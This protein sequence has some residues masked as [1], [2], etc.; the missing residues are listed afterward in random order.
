MHERLTLSG[1]PDQDTPDEDLFLFVDEASRLQD[2]FLP[3]DATYWQVF[4]GKLTEKQLRLVANYVAVWIRNTSDIHVG[5]VAATEDLIHQGS[6]QSTRPPQPIGEQKAALDLIAL[7]NVLAACLSLLRCP[8]F[9]TDFPD[10]TD[11]KVLKAA[12]SRE[13][14]ER[15]LLHVRSKTGLDEPMEGTTETLVRYVFSPDATWRLYDLTSELDLWA[16]TSE[17]MARLRAGVDI[18][19]RPDRRAIYKRV[20]SLRE[21]FRKTVEGVMC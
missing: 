19:T 14:V 21:K 17:T 9:R 1:L 13:P 3:L 16:A 10:T 11:E 6:H 8:N 4:L 20:L 2:G 5:D 15:T 12:L 7:E 18:E